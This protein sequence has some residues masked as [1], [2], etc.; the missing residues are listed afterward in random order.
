MDAVIPGWKV[1]DNMDINA[2]GR[3]QLSILK[4]SYSNVFYPCFYLLK[5]YQNILNLGEKNYTTLEIIKK[6]EKETKIKKHT[7]NSR[8]LSMQLTCRYKQHLM[9]E[10]RKHTYSG[11]FDRWHLFSSGI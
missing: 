6:R 7:F 2:A 8:Y 10:P 3:I 1:M 11:V 4:L 5:V 9:S